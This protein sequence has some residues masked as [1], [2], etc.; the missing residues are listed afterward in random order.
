MS[1]IAVSCPGL[2]YFRLL[3]LFQKLFYT[4]AC[5]FFPLHYPCHT[6]FPF[7]FYYSVG[8]NR[9]GNEE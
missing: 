1:I 3:N 4:S 5:A 9:H 7:N 2:E 8:Y 6:F